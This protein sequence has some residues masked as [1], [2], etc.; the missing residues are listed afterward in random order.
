MYL[1]L[2]LVFKTYFTRFLIKC[3]LVGWGIY[4]MEF[5]PLPVE[6]EADVYNCE[7]VGGGGGWGGEGGGGLLDV[8]PFFVHKGVSV[9][10][11]FDLCT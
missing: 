9:F 5:E 7:K 10:K 6:S 11:R 1:A 4:Q 3:S 8:K 2:V